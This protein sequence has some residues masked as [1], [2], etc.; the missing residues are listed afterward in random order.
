MLTLRAPM[1]DDST[2]GHEPGV[3]KL[4]AVLLRRHAAEKS[5]AHELLGNRRSALREERDA[6]HLVVTAAPHKPSCQHAD[7]DLPE[8]ARHAEVVDPVVGEE[9][10]VLG[11]QDRVTNDRRNV[12]VPCDLAVLSGQ[13]DE[14]PAVGIVDAADRG[15]LKTRERPQVGQVVAIEVDVMQLGD[16]QQRAEHGRGG[17]GAAHR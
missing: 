14:R 8:H 3:A 15:E 7:P 16:R 12:L 4:V 11:G 2:T 13:L 6:V 17:H 9:A 1:T 5:A 10:L